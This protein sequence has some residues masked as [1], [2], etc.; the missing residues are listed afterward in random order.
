MK[1]VISVL[2]SICLIFMF[3]AS[4]FAGLKADA[5][6]SFNS[7]GKFKILVLADVQDVYPL[8]EAE[9]A[10]I[11]AALDETKPDVVVFDGDNI[12][13][14][15]VRAYEQLLAPLTERNIPFTFVFGN[16]DDESSVLT[17]EEM[18]K[19]YQKYKGCLAYDADPSLHG[20]ATHN[21]PVL[22]SDGSKVAFNL[23]L[24]DSGDYVYD[25]E[26]NQLGYDWV[27]EDQI[28]WYE[29][30]R[31]ALKE[32]NGGELVPSMMFEHIIPKEACEKIFYKSYIPLGD[33]TINFIDNT[34]LTVIPDV[35][36]FSGF[37]FEK[38]CPGIGSDGQW[39]S[40]VD[41]KDVL[42]VVVG[43]DHV[44]GFIADV[45]GVDLIQTA[46]ATYHSYSNAFLQGG[47]IIEIDENNPWEYKTYNITTAE[48]VKNGHTE[49]S[50]DDPEKSEFGYKL[51]WFFG[52][53]LDIFMNVVRLIL[54]DMFSITK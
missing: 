29:N 47:R 33:L 2:L 53:V 35:T 45:D 44:N 4:S 41:G 40:L 16:H 54:G 5:K 32:E 26:G 49:I 8:K 51:D 34:Q 11:N 36:A 30:T 17:K 37:L 12:V 10:F 42:G 39:Q 6:L 18:L 28:K 13:C 43:H 50:D 24:M 22:S 25:A 9:I 14:S 1:K 7:D 46:G 52:K 19:E 23:W 31:D 27:R 15:D 21:L 3:S 38:S 20:C 48:L